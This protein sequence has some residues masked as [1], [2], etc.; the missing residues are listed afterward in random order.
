MAKFNMKKAIALL[1]I[2]FIAN[3]TP[4]IIRGAELNH[5]KYPKLANIFFRWDITAEE[6]KVLAKWD[7]LIIDME[8]Q[9]YSPTSLKLLKELNP[10]IK[11]LAYIASQEIRGDSGTLTGTLR[12]KLYNQINYK[13]WLKNSSGDNVSWWPGNPIVNVSSDAELV[14][15]ERWSDV[16]PRF[17]KENLIDSG[18]WD[19]V[20]YDNV[21]DNLSFMSSYNIDLNRDGQAEDMAQINEK[22]KNGMITLLNNT[23]SLL[24]QDALV[25]GNGGESYY[26]LLNGVL[27]EHFPDQ[28]WAETLNKYR[29]VNQNGYQPSLSILNSNVNNTGSETDY[30]TMRFGLASALLDDGYYSFDRGD[31]SHHELWWYDE[32]ETS[33]G[34]PANDAFNI[35]GNNSGKFKEGVWRRDFKNGLVVV[36]ATNSEYDLDLGGEYERLHGTQAPTINDGTFVSNVQIPAKDGILLLRPLDKI[37]NATYI[38]GS[39]AK[40][41]NQYGHVSRTGF[42]AYNDQFKGSSQVV[43]KDLNNDGSRE[44]VVADASQVKIYNSTGTLLNNFYPYTEKYNKGINITVGDLDNNGT[45]EI[46]TGTENGGGP[47]VRIFNSSGK[48]INPGFFAYGSSFRGGVNVTIADLEGDGFYEIVTGAGNGGGPHVRVFAPDGRNIN[49]GF[50]AYDQK[51]RGGVNVAAGDVDGDGIDEIITGPG[52]GGTPQVK[53]FDKKG[54]TKA[55]SFF[56]FDDKLKNGVEVASSDLDADGKADII[57]TT[58]NVFTLSGY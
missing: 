46:V 13:W 3:S 8:V 49:P 43:E 30:K 58:S 33:L 5:V 45:M 48:L 36:N 7:I 25:A 4:L 2:L 50:F 37:L 35:A 41:F 28:G 54:Q 12:Q 9:T 44:F 20:F 18:Y 6:A 47:Q 52:K 26:K 24:G 15:N 21:W 34:K 19:G 16:L 38:N 22:W 31:E 42:F 11:L 27:Y 39:F 1:L 40:V 14:N 17:V 51:F 32:Y 23:R 55:V 29:F 56:A 57:A 53:I 10:N